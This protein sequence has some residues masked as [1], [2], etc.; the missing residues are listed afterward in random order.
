MKI[1]CWLSGGFRFS[2]RT[3]VFPHHVCVTQALQIY[4]P[5]TSVK[6]IS[7]VCYKHLMETKQDGKQKKILAKSCVASTLKHEML[8]LM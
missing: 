4:F 8:I 3:E 1:C 6:I 7:S 2:D 5:Q